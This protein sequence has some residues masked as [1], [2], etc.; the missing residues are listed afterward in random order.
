M[1]SGSGWLTPLVKDAVSRV[2]GPASWPIAP[3]NLPGGRAVLTFAHSA[4]QQGSGFPSCPQGPWPPRLPGPWA[5]RTPRLSDELL[6]CLR[7]LRC[8]LPC[9]HPSFPRE[10]SF[11][12]RGGRGLASPGPGLW[13]RCLRC[14][15]PQLASRGDP[16]PSQ[17]KA[18]LPH[19]LAITVHRR[20]R[21]AHPGPWE[22]CTPS[23]SRRRR[24]LGPVS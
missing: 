5:P 9:G 7:A 1:T 8:C 21:S 17:L 4:A 22:Q 11:P 14:P 6:Q 13:G 20:P 18:L 19:C 16:L 23:P 12:G 15:A 24:T 3:I 10:G 2:W